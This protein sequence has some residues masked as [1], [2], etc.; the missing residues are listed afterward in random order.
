MN[1][2]TGAEAAA[3]WGVTLRQVQRLLAANRIPGAKKHGHSWMIPSD[4]QKPRDPRRVKQ[5]PESGL[6]PEEPSLSARLTASASQAKG[7]R[8]QRMPSQPSGASLPPS[9]PLPLPPKDAAS[10]DLTDLL[11][12]ANRAVCVDP[13]D[14]AG[15]IAATT[16]PLPRDTFDKTSKSNKPPT[17]VTARQRLQQESVL[18]YLRGNFARVK[19]CYLQTEGDAAARLCISSVTIAAAVSTGDY[20]LYLEIETFLKQV[21]QATTKIDPENGEI[22]AFVELCFATAYTGAAAPNMVCGWL[23]DGDFTSLL[24]EARPDALYKRAKVFQC[25]GRFEPMLAVAET[26]LSVYENSGE[27]TFHGLYFRVVCAMA[28]CA[29]GR[30]DEANRWLRDAIKIALPCGFITPFAES[31]TAFGGL[32]QPLLEQEFPAHSAA[33]NAQWQRTFPSWLTFHNRFTKDNITLI[34]PLREY[35]LARLVAGRVPYATIAKQCHISEGRLKSKMNEIFGKLMVSNRK[36]L[37]KII[38]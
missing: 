31:A 10:P 16:L 36:E 26:A 33:V 25:L 30:M 11:D 28:C 14:L 2:I 22:S 29:L 19:A 13:A 32:L 6:Y 27:I 24:P 35:E 12:S 23:K 8:L 7:R 5:A 15:L 1:Y 37:A 18:A 21:A 20:P 34:L 3:K 9:G 38:L 4:A 17:T